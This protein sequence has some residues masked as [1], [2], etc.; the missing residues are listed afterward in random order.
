MKITVFQSEKGDCLL[1]ESIDGR[2]IL[3][4]GGMRRSY[5][6]H[7]A[8]SLARLGRSEKNLDLV[9]VSHI[10]QDH[11][12]GVLQMMDDEVQWRVFEYH[13]RN[14]NSR[15]KK[16]KNPRP[17]KIR[18]IW[19]NAFHE[20]VAQN[21]G[22]IRSVL[23]ASADL[24]SASTQPGLQLMSEVHQ[25]LALSQME[26][27]SLSRRINEKELN[28]PLNEPA[29]GKLM[30]LRNGTPPVTLGTMEIAVIGPTESRLEKLREEW[31]DWLAHN[32]EQLRKL[33]QG[34]F[35]IGE[36]SDLLSSSVTT[37]LEEI[38][39][40]FGDVAKVTA[41]NLASLMLLIDETDV[42]GKKV[43]VLMTGDGHHSDIMHGLRRLGRLDE[44]GRIH[45]NVLKFPHHGS[46]QN[47]NLDFCRN[48]I[49]DH[50]IFCGNGAHENP[51]LDIVGMVLDSRLGP[52]ERMSGHTNAHSRFKF[53]FSSSSDAGINAV[54]KNR[55]HMKK[56]E[57]LMEKRAASAHRFRFRYAFSS[58]NY[59]TIKT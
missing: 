10:D 55:R 37:A 29:D 28:I 44:D 20:Q 22:S 57:A 25:E 38:A 27:M 16:P 49:A 32:R 11:I 41:P 53:W 2:R 33:K 8:P 52:K 45:V 13:K 39:R 47:V 23:A 19:H 58:R 36:S 18:G 6:S 34:A 12:S 14:G 42:E 24:L 17:P 7:V 1:L 40:R 48:V 31:N 26:A 59:I 35:P 15:F 43:S 9:Y 56:L 46:E 21:A 51:D 30:L 4:D 5:L 3:A 50:Y 54:E